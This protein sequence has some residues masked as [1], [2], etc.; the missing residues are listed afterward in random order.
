[1]AEPL[2]R[3]HCFQA[4]MRHFAEESVSGVDRLLSEVNE[5]VDG[6]DHERAADDISDRDGDQVA[7]KIGPGQVG[8]IASRPVNGLPE[9]SRRAG[10]DDGVLRAGASEKHPPQI[11]YFMLFCQGL[12]CSLLAGFGMAAGTARSWIHMVT[13]A[14]T[15]AV[16]LFIVTDMEYPRLGLVRIETFDHF[17]ADAYAGMR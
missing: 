8:K 15:L 16:A 1:M 14:L 6:R 3:W 4:L 7:N 11:I 12:A 5:P 2:G 17:L 13:F 9:G 10:L